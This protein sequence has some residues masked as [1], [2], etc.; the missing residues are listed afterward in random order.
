MNTAN[1]NSI[2]SCNS[3]QKT[4]IS[5]IVIVRQSFMNQPV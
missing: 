4:S 2:V 3:F 5:M 1:T